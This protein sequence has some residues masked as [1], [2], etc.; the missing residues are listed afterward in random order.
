MEQILVIC[1][2]WRKND[3]YRGIIKVFQLVF[4]DDEL[5]VTKLTPPM[6]LPA[7]TMTHVLLLS[8]IE[9]NL[10]RIQSKEIRKFQTVGDLLI[11]STA[12][13]NELPPDISTLSPTD[14][15]TGEFFLPA[16]S[17]HWLVIISIGDCS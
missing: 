8:A 11:G 2:R 17:K 14:R 3:Q 10:D 9:E 12:N 7:G 5:T 15:R 4:D 16:R 1:Q 6:M 13:S